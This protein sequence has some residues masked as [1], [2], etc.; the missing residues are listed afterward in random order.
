[1]INKNTSK[2]R[3]AKVSITRL[4][5]FIIVAFI[6]IRAGVGLV[7]K[8]PKTEI[9]KYGEIEISENV[10]GY[11]IKN[12][13]ITNA[14]ISGQLSI[15]VP[16]G[17][18]VQKGVTAASIFRDD[19]NDDYNKK[20][21]AIDDQIANIKS[22]SKSA[23]IFQGDTQKLD[24]DIA[25]KMK[26]V[27]DN[28]NSGNIENLSELK[29]Q[30]NDLIGK[31]L[32][33][34]GEQGFSGLNIQD[35]LKERETYVSVINSSKADIPTSDAG[36]LS[37]KVDGFE[38]YFTLN[39][40]K[41]ITVNELDKM[42][43]KDPV[44]IPKKAHVGQPVVKIINNFEWYMLCVIDTVKIKPIKQKDN[45]FI[46]LNDGTNVSAKVYS[47]KEDKNGKSLLTLYLTTNLEQFYSL[48][49]VDIKIIK[50][51]YKGLKIPTSSIVN[52]NGKRVIMIINKGVTK[53]IEVNLE[54]F[55]DDYAIIQEG[56]KIAGEKGL[57]LYDEIIINPRFVKEGVMI[58]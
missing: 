34:S 12:E 42:I 56:N 57:S 35:K 50:N 11:I 41:A 30:I 53:F 13:T 9:I 38:K 55:D 36:I 7:L 51:D 46:A 27:V 54:G 17:T 58:R 16:E 40:L 8:H 48:R 28:S 23:N 52:K 18:K 5:L 25:E 39:N 45:L 20:I 49:K 2:V 22:N 14:P 3:K 32:T 44:E 24:N 19:A 26:L 37:Y 29:S 15:K 10:T 31:K 1:M 21:K 6:I 43:I 47:I 4:V 33:V